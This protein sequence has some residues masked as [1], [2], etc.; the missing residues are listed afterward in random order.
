MKYIRTKEQGFFLFPNVI[1]HSEFL[2][3]L[4]G[5]SNRPATVIS[6]GF[7]ATDAAAPGLRCTGTSVSLK[8]PAD[9]EDSNDL[10]NQLEMCM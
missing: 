4:V 1:K 2:R 9:W 7:I 5:P 10:A 6:A 8:V 3:M